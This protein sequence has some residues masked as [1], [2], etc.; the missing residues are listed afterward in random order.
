MRRV[1]LDLAALGRQDYTLVLRRVGQ[2][3]LF[4]LLL[5]LLIVSGGGCGGSGCCCSCNV[6]LLDD[7]RGQLQFHLVLAQRLRQLLWPR[8][9]ERIVLITAV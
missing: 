1:L 2:V 9:L 3:P 5:L 6:A 4:V 7:F 8:E